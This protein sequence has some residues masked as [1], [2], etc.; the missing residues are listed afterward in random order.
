VAKPFG[1]KPPLKAY[2]LLIKPVIINHGLFDTTIGVLLIKITYRIFLM[3]YLV[4]S[5]GARLFL[6]LVSIKTFRE[7]FG[8][9]GL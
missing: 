5:S 6:F 2:F 7:G 4:V 8:F 9:Y 3:E 1:I